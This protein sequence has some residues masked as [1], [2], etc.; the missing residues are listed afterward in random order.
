M[1]K[2]NMKVLGTENVEC[3]CGDFADLHEDLEYNILFMDPP[4][5]GPDY[6]EKEKLKFEFGG[7]PLGKFC[8]KVVENSET[9]NIL[10]LKLPTNYD[11]ESLQLSM[12]GVQNIKLRFR[13][14]LLLIFDFIH[15]EEDFDSRCL[16]A[17]KFQPHRIEKRRRQE[18]E[19]EQA[20]SGDSSPKRRRREEVEVR[21]RREEVE[22]RSRRRR[23]PGLEERGRRDRRRE[24]EA[25]ERERERRDRRRRSEVM[26]TDA[27]DAV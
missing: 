4:W 16:E 7:M 23:D 24:R 2:N 12:E 3:L 1:L 26:N 19:A 20:S 17:R 10:A 14:Q 13:K 11:L 8:R 21:R 5:G 9:I 18:M 27:S 22:V 25:Y 6:I 15:D